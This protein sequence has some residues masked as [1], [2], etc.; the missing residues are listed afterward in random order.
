MAVSGPGAGAKV[1]NCLDPGGEEELVTCGH[2][3]ENKRHDKCDTD[4]RHAAT[5]LLPDTRHLFVCSVDKASSLASAF[6][7]SLKLS[8][9]VIMLGIS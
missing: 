9:T 7:E 5:S 1:S 3:D 4:A 8:L 6:S 2:C